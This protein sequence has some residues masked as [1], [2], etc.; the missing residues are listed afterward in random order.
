MVAE[1]LQALVPAGWRVV[2][3]RDEVSSRR[4]DACDGCC[5]F[6]GAGRC[7]LASAG[8]SSDELAR[9]LALP[10]CVDGFTYRL[11]RAVR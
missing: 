6:D 4:E 10:R 7:E 11:R 2:P 3:V 1:A 8:S 9:A 5:F